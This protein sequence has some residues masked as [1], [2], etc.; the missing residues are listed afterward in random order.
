M[1][2]TSENS[3][4]FSSLAELGAR[5]GVELARLPFSIRILL[6]SVARG[7]DGEVIT[8]E[9][10]RA[11]AHYDPKAP[12]AI[13]VPFKPARVLLQDFTGVPAI[14]DLAAMR[15]AMARMG[16]DPGRVNPLIPVDLVID[17]SVQV[18]DFGSPRSLS[19]NE[20]L[21]FSRNAERYAF[22]HWGR[23]AFENLRVVPPGVGICHQV[24]LEHL[25]TVV[26]ERDGQVFPDSLVGTDSHTPMVGGLGVLGWGVGGD[27]G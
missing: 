16:G 23:K 24:N 12:G 15:S 9:H 21:E 7:Q 19:R 10:V 11:L 17:H 4:S 18:D 27:R 22:L 5:E 2:A 26:Q 25:A 8:A 1:K 6:E 14:V 20:S 3:A 13:E